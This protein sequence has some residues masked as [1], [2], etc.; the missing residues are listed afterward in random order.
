MNGLK[1]NTR[2]Y[3]S[4]RKWQRDVKSDSTSSGV[5]WGEEK[6]KRGARKM[7]SSSKSSWS[8]GSEQMFKWRDGRK[9]KKKKKKV[10]QNYAFSLGQSETY[11]FISVIEFRV[12][13][14]W[15][16]KFVQNKRHKHS[17]KNKHKNKTYAWAHRQIQEKWR[18]Q[19]NDQTPLMKSTSTDLI[20]RVQ[21]I[22]RKCI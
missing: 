20:W 1:M 11:W 22:E 17:L 10:F 3:S 14:L 21:T 15:E 16:R 18:R 5:G 2:T 12:V 4:K 8:E 9:R 13:L 7:E 6:E 19:V